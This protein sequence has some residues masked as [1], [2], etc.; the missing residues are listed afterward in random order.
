MARTPHELILDEYLQEAVDFA[1]LCRQEVTEDVVKELMAEARTSRNASRSMFQWY[2]SP[3]RACELMT[4]DL[5]E[6]VTAATQTTGRR[7]R[8]KLG[9]HR[10][11]EI[12][13]G[14]QP[15]SHRSPQH[16]P[17]PK[18]AGTGRRSGDRGAAPHP[19]ARMEDRKSEEIPARPHF[20]RSRRPSKE[21]SDPPSKDRRRPARDD[22]RRPH[23]EVK[24][25]RRREK[26][27]PPLLPSDDYDEQPDS[28][29]RLPRRVEHR[30]PSK[31]DQGTTVEDGSRSDRLKASK[32]FTPPPAQGVPTETR[33]KEQ[34]PDQPRKKQRG[35][36]D[37]MMDQKP[38]GRR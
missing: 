27:P 1:R 13:S 34:L 21:E 26:V 32:A 17:P 18:N 12:V 6:R 10:R 11:S 23:E 20:R 35:Y 14:D 8:G 29:Q 25:E 3:L 30:H 9:T 33:E 15:F 2:L 19:P 7:R 4:P 16:K 28:H 22:R 24:R 38:K 31:P 37:I 36:A 5:V